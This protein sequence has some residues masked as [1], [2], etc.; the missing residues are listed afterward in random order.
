MYTSSLYHVIIFKFPGDILSRLSTAHVAF[1]ISQIKIHWVDLQI[2][3]F[4]IISQFKGEK[5]DENL[6]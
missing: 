3:L 1:T 6:F 5:N 2:N 4:G